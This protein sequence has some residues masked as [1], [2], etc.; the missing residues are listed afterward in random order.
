[1]VA[2]RDQLVVARLVG[3]EGRKRI[4]V[5][6]TAEA[7]FEGEEAVLAGRAAPEVQ[8]LAA[9]FPRPFGPG[10]DEQ[11]PGFELS[12][13]V[14]RPTQ[15]VVGEAL[16]GQEESAADHVVFPERERDAEALPETCRECPVVLGREDVELARSEALHRQVVDLAEALERLVAVAPHELELAAGDC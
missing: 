14:G 1:L 15:V 16:V 3:D 2:T 13:D 8:K 7:L 11:R 9:V 12:S 4:G 5:G 10:V 6:L